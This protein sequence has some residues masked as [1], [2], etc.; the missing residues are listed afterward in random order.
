MGEVVNLNKAKKA[1]E[2]A[3]KERKAGENRAAFGQTKG[4]KLTLKD[5]LD[6]ARRE[7]DAL[8]LDPP[9]K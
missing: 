4:Q 3:A 9:K 6:K 8:R 5:R 2:M 1:R 7:L